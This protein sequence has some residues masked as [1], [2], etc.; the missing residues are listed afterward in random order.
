MRSYGAEF[1]ERLTV[2][3]GVVSATDPEALMKAAA[4]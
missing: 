2:N 1:T 3:Q 4:E